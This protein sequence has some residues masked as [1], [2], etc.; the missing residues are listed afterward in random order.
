M[1]SSEHAMA[2][3]SESDPWVTITVTQVQGSGPRERGASMRVTAAG[4]DGTIGG[5]AL[6][7]EATKIARAMLLEG[8]ACDTRKLAL[9]PDMGQCCGGVVTLSFERNGLAARPQKAPLWIWGAGH[10]GRAIAQVMAPFEDREIMLVDVMA[11]KMPD[12]ARLAPGISPLVASD[13][14]RLMSLVPRAAHHLILTYAHD[15]DL[16]LCDALLHHGFTSA[17]LIGSR[18]K[19]ARFRKRLI[20]FGHSAKRVNEITCPIGDPSLGKHPQA[21][22]LSVAMMLLALENAPQRG[23][24]ASKITH[25][26]NESSD[27]RTA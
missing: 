15:L 14:L 24:T 4:Q 2:A 17:G 5:G 22:A 20:G 1:P 13:P 21:I 19:W 16:R 11:Q 25:D 12:P 23:N 3:E 10:V 6:E 9:G 26:T 8:R 27:R 18:T 7:W